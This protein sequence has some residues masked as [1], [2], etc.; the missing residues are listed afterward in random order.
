[1][2]IRKRRFLG[3]RRQGFSRAAEF[4]PKVAKVAIGHGMDLEF[5]MTGRK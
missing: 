3:I 2:V 4:E 1:M 5:S